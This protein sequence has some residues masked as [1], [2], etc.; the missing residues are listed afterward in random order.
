MNVNN[1]LSLPQGVEVDGGIGL[2]HVHGHRQECLYRYAT[3]F[4]PSAAVVDGEVL[5]RLWSVLNLVSRS[6]RTATLGHRAETLDDHMNDNNWKKLVGM[7]M[8]CFYVTVQHQLMSFSS[9]DLQ[10]VQGGRY[11]RTRIQGV[12]HQSLSLSKWGVTQKMDPR[13]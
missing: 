6:T 9:L 12:F 1:H 7:G 3:Y 4:I 2:F 8:Q 11:I 10:E 5:E 13:H